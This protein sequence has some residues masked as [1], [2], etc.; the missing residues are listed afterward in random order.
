MGATG[1]EMQNLQL[2]QR[3]IENDVIYFLQKDHKGSTDDQIRSVCKDNFSEEEIVSAK[4]LLASEYL[5][6]LSAYDKE[7]GHALL[8]KRNN[9]KKGKK[10]RKLDKVITDILDAIDGIEACDEN[11]KIVAKDE[12]KLPDHKSE[13]AQFKSILDRLDKTEQTLKENIKDINELKQN[14]ISLSKQ[15]TE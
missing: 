12:N 11:I 3:V 10:N 15:N 8:T 6:V 7:L 4:Q 13:L 1:Q 14:N 5:E 9:T 2:Q